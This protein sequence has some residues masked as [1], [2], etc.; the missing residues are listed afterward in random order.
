[1]DMN[2]FIR[3]RNVELTVSRASGNGFLIEALV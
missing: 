3:S 1:M 2:F